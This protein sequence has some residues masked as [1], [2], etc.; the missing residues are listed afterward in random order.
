MSKMLN[1]G[2][3]LFNLQSTFL[4]KMFKFNGTTLELCCLWIR[5]ESFSPPLLQKKFH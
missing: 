3:E 2:T 1:N 5:K 4:I